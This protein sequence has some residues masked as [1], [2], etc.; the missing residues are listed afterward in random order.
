KFVYD[1]GRC[2]WALAETADRAGHPDEAIQ[3]YDLS[4]QKMKE[5]NSQGYRHAQ[6]PI[7]DARMARSSVLAE[8][9]EFKEA[10]EEVENIVRESSLEAVSVFNVAC[11]YSRCS[12]AA[13][14]DAKLLPAEREQ[15]KARYAD[16]A[17]EFLH[18]AVSKGWNGPDAI[19]NDPDLKPLRSRTDFQKLIAELEAKE[20]ESGNRSQQSGDRK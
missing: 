4:I 3:L 20:K 6:T 11:F 8:K 5:A 14:R 13:E 17:M 7:V 19:K 16:R 9:G 1:V 15:L 12:G 18:Q 10:T 2:H